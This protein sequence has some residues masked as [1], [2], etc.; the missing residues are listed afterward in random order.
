METIKVELGMAMTTMR[1]M[2]RP[3][4]EKRILERDTGRFG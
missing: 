1:T 2:K 3:I 4:N